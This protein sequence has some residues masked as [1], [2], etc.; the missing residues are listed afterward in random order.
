MAEQADRLRHWVRAQADDVT[1]SLL[2]NRLH[3]PHVLAVT[4]G[5]GGVGKS[6][7]TLALGIAM[8]QKGARVAVLDADLGLANINIILGYEPERTVWDVMEARAELRDVVRRGPAGVLLIP[9]ASGMVEAAAADSVSI[10][11]LVSQFGSLEPE[12]DWLLVDTGAGI[13][14][15]VLAFVVAADSALIVTT[16]EPTALADAYGVVKAVHGEDS[17]VRLLLTVNRASDPVRGLRVGERL[18]ELA[19]KALGRPVEVLGVVAEDAVV[20][21]GVLRQR[22]FNLA[23]PQSPASLDVDRLADRLLGRV[24]P[25]RR[26]G[27]GDFVRRVVALNRTWTEAAAGE[28]EGEAAPAAKPGGSAPVAGV[29]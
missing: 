2:G 20:G 5:K 14:P 9:G 28:S 24:P 11:R 10:A 17:G 8:A 25:P 18:A 12:V 22:P 4:S 21:R 6:N 13:A 16:P 29:K 19:L 1:R 27:L 26:G 3:G 15:N 7:L 23:W